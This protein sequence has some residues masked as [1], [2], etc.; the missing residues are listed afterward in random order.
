MPRPLRF[1]LNGALVETTTRTM[2]GRLLLRPSS[3]LKDIIFSITARWPRSISGQ[4]GTR[5]TKTSRF[6]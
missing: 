6:L 3:E 5:L 2:Q 4:L 1:V